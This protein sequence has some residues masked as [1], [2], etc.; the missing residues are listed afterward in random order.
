MSD[1]SIQGQ[2]GRR[3]ATFTLAFYWLALITATHWPLEFLPRDKPLLASD[4]LLHFSAYAGLAFL[5]S[6]VVYLRRREAASSLGL[7]FGTT[8]CVWLMVVASG[9]CD[10]STQPLVGRD[11]EWYDWLADSVGALCGLALCAVFVWWLSG[12]GL[13]TENRQVVGED[14]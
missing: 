2:P 8:A 5:L 9:L 13:P 4:K 6:L 7:S 12:H 14:A 3:V 1:I 11:F 10:E